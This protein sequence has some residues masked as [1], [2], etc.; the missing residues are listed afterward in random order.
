MLRVDRADYRVAVLSQNDVNDRACQFL[1]ERGWLIPS[2][3]DARRPGVDTVANRE[4]RTLVVAPRGEGSSLPGTRRYGKPFTRSQ[5][6]VHVEVAAA[7]MLRKVADERTI[8]A[9]AL[10]DNPHYHEAVA[11]MLATLKRVGIGVL[12]VPLPRDRPVTADVPFDL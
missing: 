1:D 4:G 5:V 8:A 12:W 9:L 3:R 10:P 6:H 7:R 2:R 11:A